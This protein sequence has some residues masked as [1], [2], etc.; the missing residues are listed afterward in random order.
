MNKGSTFLKLARF[1]LAPPFC[2]Y[3]RE[4]IYLYG[5]RPSDEFICCS[6][7]QLIRPIISTHL[8]VTPYTVQV[9]ATSAYQEPVKSLILAKGWSDYTASKLLAS[10][11]WDYSCVQNIPFDYIVPVPSYWTRI[12]YR[13]YNQAQVI[14]RE[15]SVLTGKPLLLAVARIR[16]TK[17]QSQCAPHERVNNV[18]G[19]F[20]LLPNSLHCEGKSILLVD[21]LMTTGATL[22]ACARQLTRVQ[23]KEISALVACRV[24]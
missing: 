10:I 9:Y 6:C 21:D 19:A 14:A 1:L 24:L 20:N 23:P 22:Y 7:A 15:L 18:S 8:S 12:A 2:F 4:F 13:G 5:T 17:K 16:K 11:M 3:C